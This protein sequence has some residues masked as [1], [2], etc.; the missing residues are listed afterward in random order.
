MKLLFLVIAKLSSIAETLAQ[1]T[2][3]R[4]LW[5]NVVD[6]MRRTSPLAIDL[7]GV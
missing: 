7:Q 5:S 4:Q 6:L 1:T 2:A 3:D